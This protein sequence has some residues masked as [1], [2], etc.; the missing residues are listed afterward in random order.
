[1]HRFLE[2][3]W[4]VEV[5]K[6]PKKELHENGRYT[7]DAHICNSFNTFVIIMY[8]NLDK[9]SVLHLTVNASISLCVK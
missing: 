3:R 1:M 7:G 6:V 8:L 9:Q 5:I 4:D 2:R